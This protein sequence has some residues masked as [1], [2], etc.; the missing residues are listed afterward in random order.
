MKLL[1][2]ST[3]FPNNKDPKHGIFVRNR[4]GHLLHDF[5]DVQAKVIAPVPWFPF[6]IKSGPLAEYTKFAGVA[7][8]EQFE[9]I[10]IHHPRFLVLPKIGM[11]LTPFF[12]F[13]SVY[14]A[15]RKIKNSGF[16]FDLIDGHYFYPDGVAI[17]LVAKLMAKPFT[18]TAR[19][20][21]ISLIPQFPLARRLITKVA[22]QAS[23]IIT[24]CQ[25]L[26]D[27][28]LKFAQVD[29]KTTVLRNGV[30]LEFFTDTDKDTQQKLK[31]Y[32]C[33]DEQKL[34]ISV[35]HLIE[36]KGHHLVIEALLPAPDCYLVIAGDGPENRRL[37]AL[38]DRLDLRSRVQFAGAL[39]QSELK[40]LYQSADA[41]VLASS[42]EGWA[43]V[44]LEA[45][46]CGTAVVAT[47]LWGTP[48][49]VA[50]PEAGVL[51][52]RS[53]LD[54]AK[55]LDELFTQN[56]KRSDTRLYAEGFDWYSTSKGQYDIFTR[57]IA[58]NQTLVSQ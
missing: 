44:L 42:R 11:Y 22:Q 35:G 12:L 13:L 58:S 27:G 31:E 10:E 37:E 36:R 18:V 38:V 41:L 4:L 48:E 7:P 47:N 20:T 34:I 55:G 16:D 32:W 3:L 57:I 1:T 45:M 17:A 51:V 15:A 29:H 19:G 14:F 2:I 30:D 6:E 33:E 50:A 52:D 23:G 43:N 24:V 53:V 46:A 28:L 25:A 49:V 56:I 54:I 40:T 26:K 9:E 5:K 21:D 39:S 8:L